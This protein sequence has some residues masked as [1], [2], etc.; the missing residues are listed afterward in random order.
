MLTAMLFALSGAASPLAVNSALVSD[1][2]AD[3][4]AVDAID[5]NASHRAAVW[6]DYE[7]ALLQ[8]LR[9]SSAPRDHALAAFLVPFEETTAPTPQ[10]LETL[11]AAAD[12][13]PSDVLVQWISMLALHR[14]AQDVQVDKPLQYLEQLEP[15]NAA[16]W[17]EDLMDASRCGDSIRVDVALAQMAVSTR[18]DEHYIEVQKTLTQIYQ[19][20]PLPDVYVETPTHPAE[21]TGAATP[22]KDTFPYVMAGAHAAAFALPAYQS[23]MTACRI[24]PATLASATRA[25]QCAA[26]GRLMARQGS[27]LVANHIGYAVLR[28]SGTYTADD[29]AQSRADSWIEQQFIALSDPSTG[30]SVETMITQLKDWEE[31]GNELQSMRLAVARA[32]QPLTPPADWVDDRSPLSAQRRNTN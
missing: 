30:K 25:A 26:I 12:E 16:V 18:S 23:V 14:Y 8:S 10:T 20:F 31:T 13:A 9:D 17:M 29:V 2:S 5:P 1:S 24:I 15:D 6:K 21:G 22:D 7:V 19:R 4:T 32:G 11:N 3:E 27:I 28:E